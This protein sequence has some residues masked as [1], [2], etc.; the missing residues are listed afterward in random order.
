MYSFLASLRPGGVFA[1]PAYPR[2]SSS[3]E[4]SFERPDS[5]DTSDV[6]GAK[7]KPLP[8]RPRSNH[9]FNTNADIEHSKPSFQQTHGKFVTQRA[10]EPLNPVY[11]LPS[12][13]YEPLPPP[14]AQ[15]RDLLWTL[16]Q[17]DWKPRT[18]AIMDWSD[19]E[20]HG[21]DYLYRQIAATRDNVNVRDI[22]RPQFRCDEPSQRI[23][24]P[25][26]PAYMYDNGQVEHVVTH[27][28]R[29]GSRY[30]RKPEENFTLMCKD[31]NG[32]MV[33]SAEYPKHLIKTRKT[34]NTQDIPGA[35]ADTMW[36]GPA[37]W[38]LPGKNP[39]TCMEKETN[40]VWD[41]DGAVAGT[42][43]QG[44]RMYRNMRQLEAT[45]KAQ[46]AQQKMRTAMGISGHTAAPAAAP[47]AATTPSAMRAPTPPVSVAAPA[48]AAPSVAKVSAAQ[49]KA[50][51]E[52]VRN[53]PG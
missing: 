16:P 50:D 42:G 35:Q 18:R 29:Y 33:H 23:T 17:H 38:R 2:L 7:P 30:G 36:V 12:S 21:R 5:L 8:S 39:D 19:V 45:Q 44:I 22:T 13:T 48:A 49:R 47:I 34:N 4:M 28:P 25:L 14:R 26:R 15:A 27:V 24:D 1:C 52:S 41:I 53:L 3:V 51:I 46:E 6:D 37:V 20:G 40:K 9:P 32:E 31:V 43:G 11:K 10:T